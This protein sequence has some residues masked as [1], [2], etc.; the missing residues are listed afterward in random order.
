[1]PF[2]ERLLRDLCANQR[3]DDVRKVATILNVLANERQKEE[4]ARE[5]GGAKK[6]GMCVRPVL[7]ESAVMSHPWWW[8]WADPAAASAKKATLKTEARG[9]YDEAD[10]DG[11]RYRAQDDFD[12]M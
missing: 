12:F 10:D 5:A 4:K 11:G 9:D 2:L 6:K 3:S 1:V 7:G 8:W